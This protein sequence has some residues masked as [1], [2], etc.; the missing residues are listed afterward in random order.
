MEPRLEPIGVAKAPKVSPGGDE[1]RLDRVVSTV[2]VAQDAEGDT[3]AAVADQPSQGVEG[4]DFPA[5]RAF[6]ERS[7]HP[8]LLP[9]DLAGSVGLLGDPVIRTVQSTP[10]L[11]ADWPC[12]TRCRPTGAGR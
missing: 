12:R 1:R 3:H 2:R 10:A 6:D 11:M 4:L 9:A 7:I 8:V 5:L